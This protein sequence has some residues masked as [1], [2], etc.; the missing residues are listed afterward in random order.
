MQQAGSADFSGD[1]KLATSRSA[2]VAL[3]AA[4]H[5][6]VALGVIGAFLPV[7][8]TTVFLIV[9]AGC[10]ARGS[11]RFYNRLM[12]HRLAGPVLRD[13]RQHRAKSIRTQAVALTMIVVTFGLT[14][15]FAMT[16]TWVRAIHVLTALFLIGFILRIRTRAS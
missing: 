8:P 1:V 11:T 4:G 3:L 7:M 6:C 9:A 2:R 15:V 5:T 14:L 16:E 10:Y 12:N 13:W